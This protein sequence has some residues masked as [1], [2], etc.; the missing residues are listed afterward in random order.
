MQKSIE[1]ILAA[2]AEGGIGYQGGLP[3]KLKGDL[4]RFK[5]ATMGNVVIMGR[6]TFESLPGPLEGR[7]VIVITSNDI[8]TA[9]V[10]S[11]QTS[12]ADSL[13]RG[14]EHAH[15]LP[16]EKIFIA[17][18]AQVYRE[19]LQLPRTHPDLRTFVN[20]TAVLDAHR[21]CKCDTF[22]PDYNELLTAHFHVVLKESANEIVSELN[23]ET[24]L[25]QASHTY[26]WFRQKSL[27]E[28]TGNSDG[29]TT[30]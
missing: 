18:G 22:I 16:G 13:E 3:W 23:T 14:I 30:D 27:E 12:R 8:S 11:A 9:A 26:F 20:L 29:E 21:A 7:H 5:E 10:G 17:G 4:K 19:A 15:T 1:I 28:I 25:M 6:K 24:G 2:T